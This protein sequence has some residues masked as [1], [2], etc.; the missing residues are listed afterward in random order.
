MRRPAIQ[1]AL[2]TLLL[3]SVA[4]PADPPAGDKRSPQ[5]VVD[6]KARQVVRRDA[7]G[8]VKWALTLFGDLDGVRPPHLVWDAQRV[9]VTH[10]GGVTALDADTGNVLWHEDGPGDRLLLSGDLLLA[11][12]C[13]SGRHVGDRGRLLTARE[14][15]T[16]RAVFHRR[17][18]VEDFDP[19]PIEEVAGLFLV[20][21]NESASGKGDALLI[22]RD[23]AVR[24][25]FDREV[26]A[27]VRR[28]ED[29][30]FLTSKDV[31]RLSAED[32]TLWETPFEERQWPAGGGLVEAG[33][34][35]VAFLY[36]R[37]SD[38]G[39]ELMRLNPGT[40][41][42]VWRARCAPLGVDHSKYRH[43]AK[44]TVEGDA[45]RVTSKA[46][47]GTFVEVLDL[48]SGRQRKRTVS[49]P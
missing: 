11:T 41:K 32:K 19:L 16:G 37:I 42:V 27:G 17:L 22:D 5:Y 15:A 20:Q 4:S 29:Q 24:H 44:V 9:Y 18:P 13:T 21:T 14:A 7:G 8:E 35:L 49:E 33:G 25:R 12:D 38:S 2:L 31:V 48:R 34:D 39:V 10:N 28:G 36:G 3:A 30:V 6:P 40:G 43:E 45:L 47:G 26:V 46:S 1:A 23:G